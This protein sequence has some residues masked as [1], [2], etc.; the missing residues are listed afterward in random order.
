MFAMEFLLICAILFLSISSV[1]YAVIN[2]DDDDA[3]FRRR[4]VSVDVAFAPDMRLQSKGEKSYLQLHKCRDNGEA[5]S[6]AYLISKEHLLYQNTKYNLTWVNCEMVSL[7][8][9]NVM[10]LLTLL[11]LIF[12]Y[13]HIGIFHYDEWQSQYE[14]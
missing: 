14:P 3:N 2:Q 1:S 13:I 8:N 4:L 10:Q 12:I 9:D 11:L 6:A 5:Y 7:A